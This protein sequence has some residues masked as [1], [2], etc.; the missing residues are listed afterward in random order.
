MRVL[1]KEKIHVIAN[2]IAKLMA[3]NPHPIYPGD[4]VVAALDR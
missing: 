3:H 2:A 1:R 4:K